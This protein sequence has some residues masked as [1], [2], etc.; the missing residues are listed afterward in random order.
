MKGKIMDVLKFSVLLVTYNSEWKDI[1]RTLDSIINQEFDSFELIISDDGS[2]DN[3]F[4]QIKKYM[5][6]N[7]F[8][9]YKLIEH[10]ENQ[11]TVKNLISGLEN[12]SGKY[13][14][15]FG[16]GD[17]FYTRNALR[18][19]YDFMERKQCDSCFCRLQGFT[20]ENG[21][22]LKKN[23]VHP[24]NINV[25]KNK[26]EKL[27]LKNLILYSDNVSGASTSYKTK[28]YLENLKIIS[29]YVTYEEDIFQ[30]YAALNG[31]Y[32]EFL[33]KCL[34]WYEVSEG[35]STKK[36]SPFK[37]KLAL[38]VENFFKFITIKFNDN[39]YVKKRNKLSKLYKIENLYLRT[40]IRFFYDP[41][42]IVYLLKH[43]ISIVKGDYKNKNNGEY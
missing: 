23:Y 18:E 10:K 33:D 13:V 43:Y 15:D 40:I 12:C 29:E 31:S 3:K 25:Y 9:D 36:D 19:I 17:M 22:L 14:R 24:F 27:I 21:N 4:A 38:D 35:I 32:F 26:N 8:D 1:K 42:A 6:D 7:N 16:P 28:Y 39:I 34:I 20:E 30:V 2:K 41:Y 11:G 37:K 5:A